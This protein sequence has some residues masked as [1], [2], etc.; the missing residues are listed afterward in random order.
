MGKRF[1]SLLLAGMCMGWGCNQSKPPASSATP[2]IEKPSFES[3]RAEYER[4][5]AVVKIGMTEAD[6][7]KVLGEPNGVQSTVGVTG[8]SVKW[9][10]NLPE[11]RRFKVR[12]DE[13]G[14]V[15]AAELETSM[16]VAG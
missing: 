2:V 6:V 9:F 12:F 5:S 4:M 3:W 15:V 11:Q 14:R 13:N 1:L 10:Y 7:T 8:T 16:K